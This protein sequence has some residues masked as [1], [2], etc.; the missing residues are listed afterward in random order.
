VADGHQVPTGTSRTQFG[1]TLPHRGVKGSSI[2]AKN[3]AAIPKNKVD[4]RPS[5]DTL[6]TKDTTLS[7]HKILKGTK[8]ILKRGPSESKAT[9]TRTA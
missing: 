4:K 1:P 3:L 8:K 6:F 2:I 5:R 7:E 9:E